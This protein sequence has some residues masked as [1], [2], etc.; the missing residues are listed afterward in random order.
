MCLPVSY[1][2]D[3]TRA[4]PPDRA[5]ATIRQLVGMLQAGTADPVFIAGALARY[6]GLV[7]EVEPLVLGLAAKFNSQNRT[8][9]LE[10]L[11]QA[12]TAGAGMPA[13][14]AGGAC[15]WGDYRGTVA[16]GSAGQARAD[17]PPEIRVDPELGRLAVGLNLAAE[18]RLWLV[19]RHYFGQPGWTHR[20]Q[21]RTALKRAGVH[22][23]RRHIDRLLQRGREVFWGLGRDGKVWLRGVIRVVTRLTSRALEE[24]PDLIATNTPGVRDV[25]VRVDGSLKQFKARLYAAWLA[26]RENPKIARATL[27]KLFGVT[28]ETL[29]AWEELLPNTLEVVTSYTQTAIDPRED[30]RIVPFIPAHAFTYLTRTHRVRIRWQ[31]PNV[32]RTR[33]VRQHPHKGQ[34]RKV[35]TAAAKIIR[36][37]QPAEKRAGGRHSTR[38]LAFGR[39]HWETRL[40]YASADRY[41]AFLKR[42]GAN[43]GQHTWQAPRSVFRGYNG[44]EHA[45]YEVPLDGEPQTGAWER[46]SIRKEYTWRAA[47]ARHRKGWMRAMAG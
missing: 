45:I 27:C 31:S 10:K 39:G 2:K 29:W 18:L 11:H 36:D 41:R 47:E 26:H 14:E 6:A 38:R 24:N 4:M 34:A 46:I 21:L 13:E 7:P 33:L 3:S 5:E 44:L 42:L 23:T 19:L 17:S 28:R 16:G 40:Y 32:Y 43:I 22:H 30:D 8:F 12:K 35:R 20:Q 1:Q 37:S 15:D 25:Y 9:V